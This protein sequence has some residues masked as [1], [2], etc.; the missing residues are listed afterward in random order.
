MSYKSL[1]SLV[2]IKTNPLSPLSK[3]I[4][5]YL[6]IK[7][8]PEPVSEP[9]PEPQIDT[10]SNKSYKIDYSEK[11]IEIKVKPPEPA[12]SSTELNKILNAYK[13]AYENLLPD[14][15]YNIY[16]IRIG[17]EWIKETETW[18]KDPVLIFHIN[19]HN[20]NKEN[21]ELP[22]KIENV[23]VCVVEGFYH[24]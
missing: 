16:Y 3:L 14:K 20:R 11:K 18:S 17:H 23:K 13:Y 21:I 24:F 1:I 10:I 12:I 22:S 6:N 9:E 7:K 5:K 19:E 8:D 15:S 4:L 2:A